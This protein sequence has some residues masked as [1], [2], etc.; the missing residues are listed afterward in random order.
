MRKLF[1]INVKNSEMETRHKQTYKVN[2]AYTERYRNSAIP[3]MQRLLNE[4][5]MLKNNEKKR[6]I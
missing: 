5:E 4:N 3:Y 1:P 2:K 6:Y